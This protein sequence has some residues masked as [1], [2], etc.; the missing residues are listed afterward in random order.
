MLLEIVLTE[1]SRCFLNTSKVTELGIL[2]LSLF[3]S[4]NT[5]RE[6]EVPG[7][8][9]LALVFIKLLAFLVRQPQML[10]GINL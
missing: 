6:K 2:I 4:Q 8:L 5:N 1:L 10:F 7:K 9:C 3:Y